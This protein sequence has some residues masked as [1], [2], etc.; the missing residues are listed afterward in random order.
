MKKDFNT[1]LVNPKEMNY[2]SESHIY[3]TSKEDRKLLSN[4][5]F[6]LIDCAY[7]DIGGFKSFKDMQH[8]ID[9]SHLWYITYI[10]A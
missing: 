10:F 8:F 4:D 5:I 3:I 1:F 9:D 2:I 7:D 6:E